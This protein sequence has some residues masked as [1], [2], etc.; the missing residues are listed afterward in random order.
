LSSAGSTDAAPRPPIAGSRR[1]LGPLRK[2]GLFCL[3]VL[4]GAVALSVLWQVL[5]LPPQ[6]QHGTIHAWPQLGAGIL[7]LG[8]VLC[9]TAFLMRR[10]EGRGLDTVGLPMTPRSLRTLALGLLIG[11]VPPVLM[12]LLSSLTAGV[13]IER[14]HWNLRSILTTTF[15]M[16]A[17]LTLLSSWEEIALRGY[18]MQLLAS[19]TRPRAAAVISG[20]AFGLLHAGNPAA[21]I[22]GLVYTAIGGVLLATLVQRTGALWLACGYHAGWNVTAALV[23]GLRESGVVHQGA[24]AQTQL[25]GPGWLTGGSYGFEAAPWSVVVEILVL[26]LCLRFSAKLP[27]E[28]AAQPWFAGSRRP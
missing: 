27:A 3:A 5:H 25:L 14:L 16:A 4:G 20:V 15:P 23:F 1:P 8:L 2:L 10:Y 9:V 22:A 17:A 6:L 24:L 18:P 28:Q 11:A 12:V 21:N 7:A 13:E 26:A 19:A